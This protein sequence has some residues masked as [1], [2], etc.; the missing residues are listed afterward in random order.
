M[1]SYSYADVLNIIKVLFLQK[2]EVFFGFVYLFF[3]YKHE[4]V[5]GCLNAEFSVINISRKL[6][7]MYVFFLFLFFFF[8]FVFCFLFLFVLFFFS[9]RIL[10]L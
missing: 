6:F 3:I 7:V 2:S 9:A 10:R 8:L 5:L 4:C 1:Y